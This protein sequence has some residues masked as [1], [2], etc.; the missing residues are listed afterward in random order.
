MVESQITVS[1]TPT[2]KW[3]KGKW[4]KMQSK[5]RV[6]VEER[7][8]GWYGL[9]ITDVTKKDEGSYSLTA[10]NEHG[11]VTASAAIVMTKDVKEMQAWRREIR[12]R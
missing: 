8:G 12:P 1:P 5:D 10:K 3:M 7:E 11:T 4:T 6:V 9:T 2:V